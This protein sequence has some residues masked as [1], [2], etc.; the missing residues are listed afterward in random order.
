MIFVPGKKMKASRIKLFWSEVNLIQIRHA[1]FFPKD[2]K[3]HISIL[4]IDSGTVLRF[5]EK[6]DLPNVITLEVEFAFRLAIA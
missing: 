6:Y 4:V 5:S 1:L 2:Q 3:R